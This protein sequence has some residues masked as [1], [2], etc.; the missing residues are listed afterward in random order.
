MILDT[1]FKSFILIKIKPNSSLQFWLKF[2]PKDSFLYGFELPISLQGYSKIEGLV[3]EV[4]CHGRP[5]EFLMEPREVIFKKKI[6]K[7]NEKH[8]PTFEDIRIWNA[9]KKII[10]WYFDVKSLEVEKVFTIT[11]HEGRIEGGQMAILRV[12]FN[13][14]DHREYESKVL[15][16]IDDNPTPYTEILLKGEGASPRLLF[17]R[18]EVILPITPLDTYARSTF[19]IINDGYENLN[20]ATP[21]VSA[22]L[23]SIELQFRFPD[24][25]SVNN[26]TKTKLKVEVS[27][28][29]KKPISFT[30]RID[31]FDDENIAYPIIVSGTIDNCLLTVQP[32]LQRHSDDE[33]HMVAEDGKAIRFEELDDDA[34]SQGSPRAGSIAVSRAGSHTSRGARTLLGY[35][36]IPDH[37]LGKSAEHV[38]RWLN[39]NAILNSISKFPSDVA[40]NNGSQIFELIQFLTGK[41][42]QCKAS[43][44]NVTK[45]SERIKLLWKQYDDLIRSLKENGA[46]LNTIRPEYLLKYQDFNNYTKSNPN[47]YV[48]DAKLS[49]AKFNYLTLDAWITLFYQIIKIYY[50]TRVNYKAFRALPG[51]PSDKLQIPDYYLEGSNI[52]T[53]HEG[54]LLRWMEVQCETLKPNSVPTRI[55]DFSDSLRDGLV[56]ANVIQSYVG[57]GRIQAFKG[58]CLTPQSEEDFESNANKV[59]AAL[60]EIR[61]QT[62]INARDIIA[63]SQR[64]MM[65][66]CLFLFNNLPHY[67][68]KST[69]EFPCVLGESVT[70]YVELTNPTNR[71]ISYRVVVYEMMIELMHFFI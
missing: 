42:P 1:V 33:F 15:V 62:H 38:V 29:Y 23:G 58:L 63:P 10:K 36:P 17:D 39:F 18:R 60:N 31:I 34:A 35:T 51:I 46:L 4:K 28:K 2:T 64:E 8:F 45:K 25:N 70:K 22:D 57:L 5:R 61:L 19:R 24:G 7:A 56:F 16:Y 6:I 44:N 54:I 3:R 47:V 53:S 37:M 59:I 48:Q 26:I 32:F 13:P 11:P 27:V 14:H 66:F 40:D 21:K 20:I 9:D 12:G 43:L 41:M 69:V 71:T 30:T 65:L 67:I 52:Y 50:L 55:K 68:P 49:E